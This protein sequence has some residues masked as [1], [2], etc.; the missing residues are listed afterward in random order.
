MRYLVGFVF[1][2]ALTVFGCGEDTCAAGCLDGL[3][4]EL[5]PGL[6]S[7]YDVDLLLDGADGAFSCEGS[8]T[9]QTGVGQLVVECG[10]SAFRIQA[11][12]ESL[13]VSVVAQ[14]GSWT[15]SLN[16]N[17]EYE[18]RP[19]C[20]GESEFCPPYAVVTVRDGVTASLVQRGSGAS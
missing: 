17:P 15:G 18:R 11:A 20:P 16:E 12:P 3:W 19:R 9:N 13:E 1:V 10:V 7:S 2:L 6:S 8:P 4:V 5:E 14:D